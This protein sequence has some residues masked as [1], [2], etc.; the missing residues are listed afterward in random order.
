MGQFICH[1]SGDSVV[2]W[3]GP[4]A[5]SQTPPQLPPPGHLGSSPQPASPFC[6][7]PGQGQSQEERCGGRASR[8]KDIARGGDL[9]LGRGQTGLPDP[10]LDPSKSSAPT[11]LYFLP[12]AL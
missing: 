8:C 2:R 5:W 1:Y 11:F 9:G 12:S 10:G 4:T 6:I 7:L 3:A